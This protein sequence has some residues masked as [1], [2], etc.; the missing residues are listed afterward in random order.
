MRFNPELQAII[1]GSFS[2]ANNAKHEYV[3]AEH[4]LYNSILL[5]RKVVDIFR[6]MDAAMFIIMKQLEDYFKEIPVTKNTNVEPYKTESYIQFLNKMS[7]ECK[8]RLTPINPPKTKIE[9]I[10]AEKIKIIDIN[11]LLVALFETK[12]VCSNVMRN[13]GVTRLKLRKALSCGS[14]NISSLDKEGSAL[15][16]FTTDLTALAREQKLEILIGRQEELELTIEV[17]CRRVKNNPIICGEAGVGKTAIIEGFAQLI[18]ANDVPERLKDYTIHSLDMG[19]LIAGTKYRGTFEKRLKR[20]IKEIS[21]KGKSILFIDE[22]HT[23]IGAGSASSQLD[24][25]NMLKS[26][27]ARGRLT[28]IG[29]TTYDEYNKYFEK[30]KALSRRFQ[31]IDINEPSSEDTITI[32]NGIKF[33]YESYHNVEINKDVILRIV[34]LSEYIQGKQPDKSINCMDIIASHVRTKND[35]YKT[36]KIEQSHVENVIS[37]LGKIPEQTVKNSEKDKLKNL[38]S[39]L[40]EKIFSQDQAINVIVKAVKR[41]RAGFRAEDK[42]VANF[43]F[44]GPTGVGKTE[45]ARQLAEILSIPMIRYDMSEYQEKITVSRLIGSSPGYIGYDEGGQ[46]IDAVR[47]QPHAVLLLDEI[48]KAHSDIF[49]LLLQVMDNATL[50]DNHGRKA[51]FR[52]IILIMTSNAGAGEIGKGL[53][54]FGDRVQDDSVV[55]SAVEKTFTPE[56]R[57]RLDEVVH[58]VHLSRDIIVS[59]VKKELDVFSQQLAQKNVTITVTERCVDKLAEEGYSREFGARNVSRLIE[60]KIKSFF[61]DE[62]L[63]GRLSEGGSAVVDWKE[64]N[65]CFEYLTFPPK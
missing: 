50:T 41:S 27:L 16:K 49:N 19:S 5:E 54:G 7:A 42:P 44:A 25:G 13:A 4:V 3:T 53:I 30:D 10:E 65:Y 40:K 52:N 29:A 34:K 24:V 39:L 60:D 62:V 58:F 51:D 22:I 12:S 1:D 15:F 6:R 56:F 45:L 55:D 11:D 2:Y 33:Q 64:G 14:E 48:E 17:L 28:I 63:F 35:G 20:V 57:N 47:K 32:L 36:I 61:V 46:L 37:R 26:D 31:K 18:A 9:M 59:I 21:E 43:L 38:E 23:I 8:A